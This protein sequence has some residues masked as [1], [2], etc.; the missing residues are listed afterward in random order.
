MH[1]SLPFIK[2]IRF[3]VAT[4]SSSTHSIIHNS[5]LISLTTE[6]YEDENDFGWDFF[7]LTT[8]EMKARYMNAQLL[9][10]IPYQYMQMITDILAEE[11]QPSQVINLLDSYVDHQST[12]NLPRNVTDQYPNYQFFKEL[13]RY[14]V[15]NDFIILGGN[16]NSDNDHILAYEDDGKKKPLTDLFSARD[17]VYKNGNY[18]VVLSPERKLRVQFE[19]EELQPSYPELID[20]KITD[21]CDFGCEFCYQ[22]STPNGRHV[23]LDIFKQLKNKI[24]HYG[25]TTEFAI[26]GGEPTKH[27]QFA[28][29]LEMLYGREQNL[30]SI[31]N[32]TTKV[33]A[34]QWSQEIRL[35]VQKYV[36]GVAYSPDSMEDVFKYYTAH[37]AEIN[38]LQLYEIRQ[39]K[40][41]V[42]F[43]IHLIPE[44]MDD[45]NFRTILEAVENHNE[46]AAFT[47]LIHITLLGFKTIGRA[48]NKVR[49][50]RPEIIDIIKRL[51]ST[52]V[53]VDTKFAEDYQKYLDKSGIDRKLYTTKEGKFSMYIDA[54]ELKAYKSSYDL[55]KPID[56]VEKSAANLNVFQATPELF[57]KIQEMEIR[58]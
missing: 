10:R 54:V 5:E 29:I 21:Y 49:E 43:Y 51:S 27:P 8:K 30:I 46:T 33:P 50:P 3:G 14:I 57:K 4:N 23:S 31:L 48:E 9:C 39:D 2:N 34:D 55:D 53:G 13:K 58:V 44:I 28:D 36:T 19:E 20:L 25:I 15:E 45:E 12:F 11:E 52:P 35:A 41:A 32:F 7:T 42:K 18:W 47:Q 24:T 37:Q 16:D 38:N 26:G 1:S 17:V 40:P 56:I 6:E 22:G